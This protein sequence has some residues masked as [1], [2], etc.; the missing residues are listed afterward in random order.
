MTED[1]NKIIKSIETSTAVFR[2]PLTRH[3]ESVK[4]K[5][6]YLNGLQKETEIDLKRINIHKQLGITKIS[7]CI[8][9]PATVINDVAGDSESTLDLLRDHKLMPEKITVI[10]RKTRSCVHEKALLF[11]NPQYSI[12]VINFVYKC[13]LR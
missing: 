9:S 1:L 6:E 5:I 8:S 7:F 12:F 10:V 13:A 3:I 11:Q 2:L 4:R